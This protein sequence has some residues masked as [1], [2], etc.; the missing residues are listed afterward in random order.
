MSN[1]LKMIYPIPVVNDEGDKFFIEN[2]AESLIFAVLK[3]H[4]FLN[5][6]HSVDLELLE[7]T[8]QDKK[9]IALQKEK[10]LTEQKLQAIYK[11]QYAITD[12]LWPNHVCIKKMNPLKEQEK[13]LKDKISELEAEIWS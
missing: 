2:E 9:K 12:S 6:Q 11:T 8:E 10:E 7:L 4:R 5:C 13:R 1:S 3:V